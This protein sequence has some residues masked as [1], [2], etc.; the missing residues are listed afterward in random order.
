M[1]NGTDMQLHD[2]IGQTLLG[3]EG[4][5]IG[6]ISEV[7][8][9]EETKKPE[10]FAV[11]TGFFGSNVSFVPIAQA[12]ASDDT[13]SVPYTKA[14]VKEAPNA[15]PDGQL[16]QDEEARLYSYYGI[17]YSEARS[18][19]GLPAGTSND[20]DAIDVRGSDGADDAMTRSEEELAVD[21]QR[22]AAGV[23]RLRKW[24]E[25]EHQTIT[26]PVQ[27]E[28]VRIERE[29]VSEGNLDHALDGP[30]ITENVHEETLYEE[31]PVVQKKVVPKERVRLAKDVE[32][33]EQT[34][35]G[36]VRKEHIEVEGD[37]T[38]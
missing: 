2:C 38:H 11:T 12:S 36:D 33:E 35:G 3:R 29:P 32:V 9:D 7:Y 19:S 34:V 16:S 15:V 20:G 22:R 21:T 1:T 28:R 17:D 14:E 23:A 31:V 6:K 18:D 13:I 37:T 5:K 24:V 10:W 4:E 27:R 8:V 26:I 30:E 25:T